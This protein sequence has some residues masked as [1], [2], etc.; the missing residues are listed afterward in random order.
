VKAVAILGA[1]ALA[2]LVAGCDEMGRQ[3]RAAV[4]RGSA[5]FPDGSAV[6]PPPSGTIPR[7]QGLLDATLRARPAMTPQLVARGQDRYRIF[8]QPCHDPAGY[9][10]GAIPAR[11]FPHPPSLHEARLV[12]APSAYLVQVIGDGH[13]AMYGYADRI[14][15]ADRWAIA[16]YIR[17]LQLSQAA[18][19]ER[20]PTADR[21]RLEASDGR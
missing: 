17:A 12:R 8:C 1:A 9:G 14:P 3:P 5:L 11:G 19:A 6:Q 2:G 16:A 20:L 4:Y 15:A 7:G 21:S 13:G 10:D 18:P